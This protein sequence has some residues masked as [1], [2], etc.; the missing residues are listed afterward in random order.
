[1]DTFAIVRRLNRAL[2][3]WVALLLMLAVFSAHQAMAQAA[4]P[5]YQVKGVFNKAISQGQETKT[6]DFNVGAYRNVY[7]LYAQSAHT[8]SPSTTITIYD[9]DTASGAYVALLASAAYSTDAEQN[10]LQVGPGLADT[11]NR[12]ANHILT[13]V[14][15]VGVAQAT[16]AA[17]IT[18]TL[19]CTFGP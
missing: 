6:Y 12:S 7:C 13:T 3:M 15:R 9:K 4:Q 19:N 17:T 14:V 5:V 2:L 8:G 1:M 18:G 10:D 16:G 11:T